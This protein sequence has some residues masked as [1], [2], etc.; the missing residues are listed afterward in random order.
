MLIYTTSKVVD[1]ALS[2]MFRIFAQ[3]AYNLLRVTVEDCLSCP[4]CAEL[5]YN[6]SMPAKQSHDPPVEVSIVSPYNRY[7]PQGRLDA[8][9]SLLQPLWSKSLQNRPCYIGY[10]TSHLSCFLGLFT[11]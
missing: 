11:D 5:A 2:A 6:N 10:T 7:R 3:V 8:Q 4:A 1:Y 9:P